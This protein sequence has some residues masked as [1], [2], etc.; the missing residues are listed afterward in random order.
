MPPFSV[1]SQP[2]QCC[3]SWLLD[4]KGRPYPWPARLRD[5]NPLRYF[6]WEY[7]N[8]LVF[9]TPVETDIELVAR[10]VTACEQLLSDAKW[11]INCVNVRYLQVTVTTVNK[12]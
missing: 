2:S 4:W 3:I 11:Y 7:L 8:S 12:K 10:I 5:L 9:E 1:D 6:L